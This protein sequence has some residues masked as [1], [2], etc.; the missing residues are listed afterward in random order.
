MAEE[1]KIE[2]DEDIRRRNRRNTYIFVAAIVIVVLAAIVSALLVNKY[3]I[4]SYEIDGVSMYPTL[5]GAT[6]DEDG[7]K[8]IGDY[9]YLNK[10][11]KSYS[12]GD[13][14]VFV[15]DTLS[16]GTQVKYVKRVI[17]T[18]GDVVELKGDKVYVNDKELKED[19]INQEETPHYDDLKITVPEGSYFVLGDNRNHSTDSR[20]KWEDNDHCIKQEVIIGKA[21]VIKHASGKISF[22]KKVK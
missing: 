2:F 14:I 8:V 1:E 16:D 3:V 13:V 12:Y 22:I 19:Y 7:N 17:G 18:P 9:V 21:F 15:A 20:F 6:Y 5:Y 10:A 4:T 11:K